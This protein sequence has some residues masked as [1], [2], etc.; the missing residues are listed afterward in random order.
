GGWRGIRPHLSIDG[1]VVHGANGAPALHLQRVEADL[2]WWSLLIGKLDFRRLAFSTPQLAVSRDAQGG[3]QV[4]GF[5]LSGHG[6][7]D[8]R[9]FDWL[10]SQREVEVRGGELRWTDALRDRHEERL[11]DVHLTLSQV[12]GRHRLQ[13]ALT[14]PAS[15]GGRISLSANWRGEGLA[16]WRGWHGEAQLSLKQLNLGE[17]A[18]H[19]PVQSLPFEQA[20]GRLDGNLSLRFAKGGLVAAEVAAVLQGLRLVQSQRRLVLPRFDGTLSWQA[21]A[22]EQRVRLSAQRI[23]AERGLACERCVLDY[24]AGAGEQQ[25][26]LQGWRIAP[27]LAY[28]A[29]LP[30]AWQRRLAPLTASGHLEQ[31]KLQWQD[32]FKRYDGELKL[33]AASLGWGR[34]VEQLAGVDLVSRFDENGGSLQLKSRK[35]R[36]SLPGLFV[37]PLALTRFELDGGWRR[38][39]K[40]WAVQM[41]RLALAN[42]DVALGASASYHYD[43]KGPGTLDL[44]GTI[45]RLKAARAYAYLP[46]AVGEHT[47]DWLAGA[48]RQGE[49]YDGQIRVAGPLA[50]FPFP[51][52]VG[53]L[54]RITAKARDVA[55]AY[56]DGWPRLER[57]AGELDFHG[58]RMDI[59]ASSAVI[60]AVPLT[61]TRVS[62]PDLGAHESH[63]IAE[64][65]S[66]AATDHFLGFLRSSPLR[67]VTQ[68]YVDSLKAQGQGALTLK[69]DIPLHDARLARVAG[70]Y[71][72]HDNVLDFGGA[73]PQLAAA[74]GELTFTEHGLAI[75]DG[76]A[77]ALGGAAR[78]SGGVQRGAFVMQLAGQA[79]LRDA[80]QRYELPQSERV[81]GTVD[82]RGQ[83]TATD[84]GYRFELDSPLAGARLDLPPPLAKQAGESRPLRFVA[85]SGA[86]RA[87]IEL[88]YG[89]LLQARFARSDGAWRGAIALGAGPAPPATEAGIALT[90]GWPQLDVNVWL[91][92]AG[93]GGA[94]GEDGPGL[95]SAQLAFDRVK[96]GGR[97]LNNVRFAL[98]RQNVGWQGR[99]ASDQ[100]EGRFSWRSAVA[101]VSPLLDLKLSRLDLP[102]S[103][104]EADRIVVRPADAAGRQQ[105]VDD[106]GWP[107]LKLAV[108][109][110]RYESRSLGRLAI[111]AQPQAGNW[112]LN[113]VSL[114]NDDGALTMSGLWRRAEVRSRV[115]GKFEIKSSDFGQMLGR[116]GYPDTIRRAPGSFSGDVAWDGAPFPP[117]LATM[118]GSLKL[119]VGAGQFAKIDPGA[120]RLLSVLS[121]QSLTRRVKLDF[122]DVF[123]DGFEFDQIHGEAT[124]EQ[125]IA[126]TQDLTIAGPGAQVLFKGE[127]NIVAGTQNLRV[128]IVPV[129][130][131]TVAIAAGV[132]NPLAGV[133]A[134]LLQ[135]ALKDPIGNL[136]AYEYDITG[137]MRDPQVKRVR[138]LENLM[139]EFGKLR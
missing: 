79:R 124:I 128:R 123:S 20:A 70:H 66:L 139:P 54:F 73:I 64:G 23:V 131:D 72:F 108:D 15:L 76:R 8:H 21:D 13:L 132:I 34:L 109:D 1:L 127:A 44:N 113:E 105:A 89:K 26:Q 41:K 6:G 16:L 85:L 95:A 42:A 63:L 84:K 14:P 115:S 98:Q 19:F 67:A 50:Q 29:W 25:L 136:I 65:Q 46:R 55:L 59:H 82:Y 111:H 12:F 32:D 7:G 75:Q 58:R 22:R 81:S 106:R 116:L 134:F 138:S 30:Q 129:V 88:G 87:E 122:R 135:R 40:G 39:P 38:Q 86:G 35:L 68:S 119:E 47:L 137:S 10:L 17:L 18:M 90:G 118:Q 133:A 104:D 97:L 78:F 126:R 101:G 48:L 43:G 99:L 93:V 96:A 52:D 57:I 110:F 9:F 27:M 114:V 53:G 102:L 92:L 11:R 107:A 91:G 45:A 62:I 61:E 80:W 37:E 112:R 4:A 28:R 69:L 24:R 103:R 51:D 36:A 117:D 2:S 125:G 130:G 100:A 60:G 31:A 74:A 3:W 120:A 94:G 121:L 33:S 83:L 5:S 49:A 56:A 71:R 77:Q